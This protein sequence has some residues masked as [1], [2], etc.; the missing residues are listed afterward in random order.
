LTERIFI[1]KSA[2]EVSALK[3][4][5]HSKGIE[6]LPH[7]FLTFSSSKISINDSF[8]VVF[9]GSPRAVHYLD[10][11]K[12]IPTSVKIACIGPATGDFIRKLGYNVDFEGA[13]PI[14]LVGKEFK[15][16]CGK[17]KVLFPHSNISIKTI[18]SLFEPAQKLEIETYKTTINA[19]GIEP[20]TT[21]VFTSPSNVTG[22]FMRNK[23]PKNIRTIAWGSSTEKAL[24]NRGIHVDKTLHQPSLDKLKAC[25]LSK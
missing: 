23:L 4:V 1:S 15:A 10:D 13:G 24:L 6:I 7:S 22:F 16:W 25:L 21:Y 9:F 18:S 2:S 12:K 8:E 20:C 11:Q 17:Q 14:D 3:N 19:C 5:L